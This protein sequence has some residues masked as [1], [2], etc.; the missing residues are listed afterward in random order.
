METGCRQGDPEGGG[1]GWGQGAGRETQAALGWGCVN[2][3]TGWSVGLFLE[4]EVGAAWW[5][6]CQLVSQGMPMWL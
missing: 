6:M 3:F 4:E 2:C 1:R 5:V